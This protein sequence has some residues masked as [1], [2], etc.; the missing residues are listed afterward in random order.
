MRCKIALESVQHIKTMT[1]ERAHL[2]FVGWWIGSSIV[3][4]R[5]SWCGIESHV[6]LPSI[7][8]F[9]NSTLTCVTRV[10]RTYA[11]SEQSCPVFK[12]KFGLG[13]GWDEIKFV[14][15]RTLSLT[16][17]PD[18]TGVCHLNGFLDIWTGWIT[19]R[20]YFGSVNM[21][22]HGQFYE[23]KPYWIFNQFLFCN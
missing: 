20:S 3:Y 12:C 1:I 7:M 15:W 6:C 8:L 16:V 21:L 2:C 10:N 4:E 9:W 17:E 22:L 14:V 18:L 19:K 11:A 5:G 13:L 23:T